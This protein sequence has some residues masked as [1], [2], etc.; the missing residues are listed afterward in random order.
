[1]LAR[2][3]SL[4]IG[5]VCGLFQ[6]GYFYSKKRDFDLRAH[7]SG[8]SGTT[9]TIR[10]MGWKAGGIVFAGDVLKCICAVFLVWL[11]YHKIWGPDIKLLEIYAAFGSILGHD[12]PIYLKFKGGKGM[13]CTAGLI[14]AA[15]WPLIPWELAVF[16]IPV[17]ATRYVSLGSILASAGLPVFTLVTHAMGWYYVKGTHFPE[18]VVVMCLIGALNISRHHANI[19]RLLHGTENK[20][21]GKKKE[22]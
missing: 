15:A 4:G 3:L 1:M 10:T 22:Q 9:N 12:F 11:L 18:L 16:L 17:L 20:I 2:I 7:G 13:A 5:Y 19:G 21:G 6:T 14:M 8:N